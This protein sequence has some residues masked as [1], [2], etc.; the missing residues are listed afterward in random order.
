MTASTPNP[1]LNG[2]S[3]VGE[4][5]AIISAACVL[6]TLVVALRCYSRAVIL[7]SFGLDDA[8]MV[9]AQILTIASAVAI[10]LEAKYGLGRHSWMM[11]KEDY[12]PYMKSFYSSIA[13]YNVAVCMTKISILLQYH[14]LFSHTM[15]RKVILGGLVFLICWGITLCFLL[16]LVCIPVDAFWNPD[17]PGFCLDNG[18]IW[19]VMAGVNVFTD[20]AVFSMPIPVISSL[21]L[22]TKQKAMLLIVFTL[23]IF[24]CAVSIYRIHTLYSAA[25]STDASWD[26][27]DA[28]VFSFLE[29]S[30]GV[31]AICLPT[32]RPVLMQTMPRIFGSLLRS[33]SGGYGNGPTGPTAGGGSRTPFSGHGTGTGAVAGGGGAGGGGVFTKVGSSGTTTLRASDST[34][35]LRPGDEE[36]AL[37]PRSRMGDDIEFGELPHGPLDANIPVAKRYSVS[38]VGGWEPAAYL[39]E[40]VGGGNPVGIKTTTVVTQKVSFAEEG[41]RLSGENANP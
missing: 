32:L 26:N 1:A 34:E 35:G 33:N 7:R 38:V 8:V 36:I 39:D 5:I 13:V 15:I 27:V 11:P 40:A 25:H 41:N 4:I 24:P 28:A 21:H 10:G 14:R 2:E 6:S 19:Y 30:V 23:G 22:P 12:I 9:P 3:R 17:V 16:P 37:P 29:L 31:I 18:T 20:F